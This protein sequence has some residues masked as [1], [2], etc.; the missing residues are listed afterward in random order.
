MGGSALV[1]GAASRIG[2]AMVLSLAKAGM[3]VAIHYNE[4]KS[5]ADL[6]AREAKEYGVKAILVQADLLVEAQIRRVVPTAVEKL[7]GQLNLL[8]NNASIFEYDNLMTA[9]F[10]SWHRHI[11]SNLK[12]PLFLMQDFSQ[13]AKKATLDDQ[14]ELYPNANIVNII[15]QRVLKK[16]PEFFTY[17]LGKMGLWSVTQT[18]AQALAPHVRVNG[19]APGPTLKGSRQTDQHFS[20][21]RKNT[22]LER[23]VSTADLVAALH[24]IL[25]TPSLTGQLLCV[26]GGQHL[27]WKTPDILGV[28]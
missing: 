3:N 5:D 8:I 19:I 25:A 11:G 7:Q 6:V 15:D 20:A 10:D 1:T 18:A 12:A 16:T 4:S 28:E 27:A 13:Q 2:K 23:G 22:I 17:S 24:F 26:D 14:N 9:S 21:Q